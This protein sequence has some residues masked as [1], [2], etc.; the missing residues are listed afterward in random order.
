ML[1]LL[2]TQLSYISDFALV[3]EHHK[4]CKG[5]SLSMENIAGPFPAAHRGELQWAETGKVAQLFGHRGFPD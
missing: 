5:D 1:I 4:Y 2:V 3:A